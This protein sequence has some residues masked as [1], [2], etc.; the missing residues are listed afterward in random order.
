MKGKQMACVI[1]TGILVLG[2]AV[3]LTK[4]SISEEKVI[5]T[6][7]MVT[8]LRGIRMLWRYAAGKKSRR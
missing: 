2:S 6:A 7:G 8:Q 1:A 5:E 3:V 4:D